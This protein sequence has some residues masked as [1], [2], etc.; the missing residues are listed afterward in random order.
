MAAKKDS[1]DSGNRVFLKKSPALKSKRGAVGET[2]WSKRFVQ[3]LEEICDAPRLSR[4]KSYA[5]NGYVSSIRYQDGVV[6][7]KVRGS[8]RT[9]YT[10]IITFRDYRSEEW[11]SVIDGMAGQAIISARLLSGE[12]PE[13]LEGVFTSVGMS[14]FPES[15]DDI[16]TTCSCPDWANPCKHV[17]AVYYILAEWFDENPFFLFGL[18]GMERVEL[19]DALRKRRS[20]VAGAG[21]GAGTDLEAGAGAGTDHEF[22]AGTDAPAEEMA[23]NEVPGAVCAPDTFSPE[24]YLQNFWKT[25][26]D[27][28]SFAFRFHDAPVPAIRQLGLSPFTLGGKNL[29]ERLLPVYPV[30]RKY[31]LGLTEMEKDR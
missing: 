23:P 24:D 13:E 18:R 22:G 8:M 3:T 6:E 17:A 20:A 9:P 25:R 7:A 21:A 11:E 31:A 12:M 2:W 15:D 16:E 30:A 1:P 27:L 4:G 28:D 19:L 14:L 29:S 10:V 5:R 26:A